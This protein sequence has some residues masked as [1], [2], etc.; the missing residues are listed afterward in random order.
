ME[1]LRIVCR[2]QLKLLLQIRGKARCPD[3]ALAISRPRRVVQ[4]T[5]STDRMQD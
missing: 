3:L 5:D 4:P 2:E 1:T